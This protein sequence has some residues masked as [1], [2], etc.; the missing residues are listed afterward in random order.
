[1]TQRKPTAGWLAGLLAG[2][3]AAAS[4][5]G[6]SEPAQPPAGPVA[7]IPPPVD[8]APTP[9][10]GSDS[11]EIP[12]VLSVERQV[13]L[14]AQRDGI[15]EDILYDQGARVEK[16]TV[17]ARLDDRDLV[18][19]L[20]RARADLDVAQSNV[21]YNEAEVKARQAAY[22]RAQEMRKLG[23][24]SDADLEEAE[25]RAK[26]AE[27][28]LESWRA[29]VT[30]TQA[31]IRILE[32][33]LE[34]TGVR[35]PFGG[36]VAVRYIRPG[37][38]VAKDEKCFRLS[39]LAP[40]QVQFLV[41]ETAARRPQRGDMVNVAPA[42]DTQRVYVARIQKVSPTVDAASGSYDVTAMLTGSDLSELRPGMAVRVLWGAAPARPR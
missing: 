16:G 29:V 1:M 17:L 37:Q 7:V 19:K 3:L 10:R 27:Y 30:R 18:A 23:L 8:T 15:V 22:R 35:A 21:K 39:Q 14:L 12:S 11:L 32:L 40:L 34:K 33:D 24:N 5:G 41:P 13:D 38:N 31:D 28:D 42:S 26:G 36:V 2:A 6:S 20:D 9:A 4:C 25:F